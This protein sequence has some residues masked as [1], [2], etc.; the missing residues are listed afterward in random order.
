[1]ALEYWELKQRQ[2]GNDAG[3]EMALVLRKQYGDEEMP[4]QPVDTEKVVKRLERELRGIGLPVRTA[5]NILRAVRSE[6]L[7]VTEAS[8][9]HLVP[10]EDLLDLR[11]MGPRSLRELRQ[12][13]PYQ[14]PTNKP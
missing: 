4:Q 1:M 3:A 6:Q 11:N 7:E 9:L 12:A 8:D 14:S 2:K 10:D 5:N 13:I